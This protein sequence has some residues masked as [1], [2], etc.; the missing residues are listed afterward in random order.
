MP[1]TS[2]TPH[3]L[4]AILGGQAVRPEGPPVWPVPDSRVRDAFDRAYAEGSWGKYQGGRA[5][6]LRE[7]LAAYHGREFVELCS[8]GTAAVEL[9]L[10][11]LKVGPGDEVILAAYDF[12]G[13]CQNVLTVGALPVLVDIHPTNWNFN[14]AHLAQALSPKTRAILVSHLHGGLSPMPEIMSFAQAHGLRVIEDAAQMPGAT[15]YGR[16]A[17]AWGH[18][19][20]LSFGGSKLLCAGRGGALITAEEAVARRVRL[21]CER[22]NHAYPLSELQA[23]VLLPQL[24]SLDVANDRRAENAAWLND[25]LAGEAGLKAFLNPPSDSKPGYY[26]LGLM[27]EPSAFQG[28]TRN[29]FAEAVRAEGISLSPGFRSL[30]TTHAPSRY[31]KAGELPVA[32]MADE[33]VL[34]LHHPV[35]L[36]GREDLVQILEAVGKVR[37][38]C[39]AIREKTDCGPPRVP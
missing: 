23:A 25:R 4:P 22:G 37:N 29:V 17:G 6:E 19:A 28:L 8:S 35:L 1:A 34:T 3:S 20:V 15:I 31:R 30:H 27:Y 38:H 13:N 36:G 32:T 16:R 26:K 18:V 39:A 7:R 2:S 12:R 11:G 33:L 14:P 21:Y 9:A 24:E 5:E 10:R